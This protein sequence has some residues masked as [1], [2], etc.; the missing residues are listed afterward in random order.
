MNLDWCQLCLGRGNFEE[1]DLSNGKTLSVINLM[2]IGDIFQCP[3]CGLCYEQWQEDGIDG[4]RAYRNRLTW[5][6][7]LYS[8]QGSSDSKCNSLRGFLS[9]HLDSAMGELQEQEMPVSQVRLE[10]IQLN[11]IHYFHAKGDKAAIEKVRP[12]LSPGI[13]M[14]V[15][16]HLL[17]PPLLPL[18]TVTN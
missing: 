10:W 4:L 12:L 17:D 13:L 3:D 9:K 14:A 8:L 6:E 7:T 15:E 18:A 16:C 5:L 2:A 11:L 1:A